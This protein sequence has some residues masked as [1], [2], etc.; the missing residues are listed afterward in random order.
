MTFTHYDKTNPF[1]VEKLYVLHITILTTIMKQNNEE[2]VQTTI[3][4]SSNENWNTFKLNA[5]TK[6]RPSFSYFYMIGRL[7]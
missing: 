4:V 7:I 1:S 2:T 6:S 5:L 3:I